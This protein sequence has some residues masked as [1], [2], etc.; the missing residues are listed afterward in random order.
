MTL[1]ILMT[2]QEANEIFQKRNLKKKGN[3]PQ[4][5]KQQKKVFHRCVAVLSLLYFSCLKTPC[6]CATLISFFFFFF[7]WL[8]ISFYF[9][10][11][12]FHAG[13]VQFR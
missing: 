7:V 8:L 6:H 11:G 13:A 2:K 1:Q 3:I 5:E 9:L 10:Y 12:D 4:K